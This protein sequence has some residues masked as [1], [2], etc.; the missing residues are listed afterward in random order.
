MKTVAI[1]PETPGAPDSKYWA[2]SGDLQSTGKTAGA[3]LDSL[4][5]KLPQSDSG[6]LIVVQHHRPDSFFGADQ[7]NRLRD[8]MARWRAA[9]DANSP[10]PAAEQQE[11]ESLIEA[12]LRAATSRA[13]AM[14]HE[15]PL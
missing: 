5:E 11:L 10:L 4:S 14:A 12:E 15:M 7:C 2:I 9:R 8:L 13:A 3:A 6:T 1:I